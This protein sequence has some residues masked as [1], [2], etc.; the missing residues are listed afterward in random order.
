MNEFVRWLKCRATGIDA[1][2]YVF[3]GV[4]FSLVWALVMLIIKVNLWGFTTNN[5]VGDDPKKAFG[6]FIMLLFFAYPL[7]LIEELL[8]R[9]VF[10]DVFIKVYGHPL[11]TVWGLIGNFL[12]FGFAHYPVHHSV[13]LCV[14]VQGTLG[15][16]L[17]LIYLKTGGRQGKLGQ[18]VFWSTL[19]HGSY[20]TIL[21]GVG[22]VAVFYMPHH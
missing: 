1:L 13:F 16:V 17:S 5:Q 8:F 9:V 12:I 2:G 3:L 4:V 6:F 14:F 21:A 22:L 19:T 11:D 15:V 7:A 20:N 10:W 18:G